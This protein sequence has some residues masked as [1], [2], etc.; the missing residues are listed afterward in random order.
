MISADVLRAIRNDLPMPVTAPYRLTTILLFFLTFAHLA[1]FAGEYSSL[2]STAGRDLTRKEF[3]HDHMIYM[4]DKAH[5]FCCQKNI[6][7]IDLL[8]SIGYDF[9]SAV[10]LLRRWL[11]EYKVNGPAASDFTREKLRE[12]QQNRPMAIGELLSNFSGSVGKR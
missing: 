9:K 6:N 5:C 1:Y 2:V 8:L 10:A 12:D 11:K 7:N 3:R 4:I